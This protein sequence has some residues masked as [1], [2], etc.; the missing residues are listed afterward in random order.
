MGERDDSPRRAQAREEGKSIPIEEGEALTAPANRGAGGAGGASDATGDMDSFKDAF[1]RLEADVREAEDK[2]LR[3]LADL[4]NTRKHLARE[5]SNW[6]RFGHEGVVRDLLPIL[7]NLERAIQAA[8]EVA[9]GGREG[10]GTKRLLE[11]IELTV[12]QFLDALAKHGVTPID[13]RGR[14]FDPRVHEA[15]QRVARGDVPPGTVVEEFLKGYMLHDRLLRA[16]KVAV[17]EQDDH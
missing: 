7:D 10:E 12:R 14:P 11:G 6:L 4:D 3:A 1:E 15:V 2:Y 9:D 16:A 17:S 5:K 13:S 8:A